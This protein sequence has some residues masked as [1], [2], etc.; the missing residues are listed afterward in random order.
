MF[1]L[2][3][4]VIA[5]EIVNHRPYKP[6]YKVNPNIKAQKSWGIFCGVGYQLE[7]IL[8]GV[9]IKNANITYII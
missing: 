7:Y 6:K 3:L 9:R 4:F 8:F 2:V 1:I 5:K